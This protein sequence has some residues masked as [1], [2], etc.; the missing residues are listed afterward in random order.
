[1]QGRCEKHLFEGAVDVCRQCAHEFCPECLVYSFGPK[2]PPFCVPCAVAAAG[3]RSTAGMRPAV[4]RKQVRRLMKERRLARRAT[5]EQRV[6][7]FAA[8]VAPKD[9]DDVPVYDQQPN[10][11]SFRW[12]L[13]DH[14]TA[15]S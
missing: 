10:A 8:A 2:Q 9:Y 1:M 13:D 6:E 11:V 14:G 15:A 3:I 4:E 12:A 7:A 5:S